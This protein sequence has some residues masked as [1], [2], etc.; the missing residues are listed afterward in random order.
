MADI[1]FIHVQFED[2]ATRRR[3][4]SPWMARPVIE[5]PK[6]VGPLTDPLPMAE[7]GYA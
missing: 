1:H 2:A 7:R 3:P 4:S 5:Q 6:I